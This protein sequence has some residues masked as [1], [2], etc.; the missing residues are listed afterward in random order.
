MKS[1]AGSKSGSWQARLTLTLYL[2]IDVAIVKTFVVALYSYPHPHPGI[3]LKKP[4]R[5]VFRADIL[6]KLKI[7]KTAEINKK[8]KI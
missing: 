4:A 5:Y 8:K 6:L 7:K 1:V 3:A 2:M